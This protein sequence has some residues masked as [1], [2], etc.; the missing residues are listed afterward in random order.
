MASRD[1]RSN[2]QAIRIPAYTRLEGRAE[3]K[4][5]SVSAIAKAI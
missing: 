5:Q 1:D 3:V 2:S 4:D